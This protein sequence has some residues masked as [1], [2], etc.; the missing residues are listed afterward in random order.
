MSDYAPDEATA[1][2]DLCRFLSACYYEPA[3][4]FAEE[5][6]FDSML[7]AAT[8]LS[9]DLA[10][11][12]RKLG[13]AFASQDLQT[14][15]VDYT[16][17]FLGP[18]EALAQ[19]YGSVWLGVPEP[20]DDIPPPAVVDLYSEGGFDVDEEFMELPDHIAVELEFLYL[21]TFNANQAERTGQR[22]DGVLI[23]RLRQRFLGE[24]LGAW[25][26]PFAA[27][28][29]AGAET[30]FYRELAALTERFV[31]IE[32]GHPLDSTVH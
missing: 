30:A 1:R 27:A 5:K 25:I 17:L 8:R 4:E 28:V 19:P 22:E 9:P 18:I 7:V 16:R 10:D 6:L 26:A 23:E 14:L 20:T 12:A 31:R 32:S 13:M 11:H 2:A 24:H 21:L 29:T 3:A 15:L